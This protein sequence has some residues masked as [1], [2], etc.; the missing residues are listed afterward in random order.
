MSSPTRHFQGGEFCKSVL[1]SQLIRWT[2]ASIS[3]LWWQRWER[4]RSYAKGEGEEPAAAA[5]MTRR[6]LT[7][8]SSSSEYEI[9]SY[10]TLKILRDGGK[11]IQDYKGSRNADSIIEYLKKQAGPASAEIKS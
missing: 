1:S 5:A 9:R 4:R 2:R 6:W 3:A 10:P 7:P 11:H 8:P